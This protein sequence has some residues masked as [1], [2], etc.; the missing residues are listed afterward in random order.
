[1]K[2]TIYTLPQ[3]SFVAGQT[4]NYA[5]NL[6]RES[7]EPFDAKNCTGTFSLLDYSDR[8]EDATPVLTKQISFISGESNVR[9]MAYVSLK[10]S[11]TMNL[12]GKYIYQLSIKDPDGTVEIPNQGLFY[13][14]KNINKSFV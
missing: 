2:N 8:D 4:K 9:N 12:E 7:K 6:F 5:W 10:P 14:Y 11:D 1:M 13:I 3:D